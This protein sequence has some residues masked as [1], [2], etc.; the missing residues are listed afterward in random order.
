MH[1]YH[2]KS[3]TYIVN[4]VFP[5]LVGEG[6]LREELLEGV[7]VVTITL[8]L[9]MSR[10]TDDILAIVLYFVDSKWIW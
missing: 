8:D 2:A 4:K 9:W 3:S 6:V 1:R 10:A 5:A 7:H